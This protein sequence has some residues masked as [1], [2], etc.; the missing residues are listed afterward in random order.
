M[1]NLRNRLEMA[2]LCLTCSNLFLFVFRSPTRATVADAGPLSAHQLRMLAAHATSLAQAAQDEWRA[3][4]LAD[5]RDERRRISDLE[6][7]IHSIL[8]AKN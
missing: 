6:A 8:Q 3:Q 5:M 2:W 4:L 1:R 7:Q